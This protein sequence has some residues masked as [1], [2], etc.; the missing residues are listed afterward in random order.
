MIAVAVLGLVL[1]GGGLCLPIS[2][3]CRARTGD[4]LSR[5]AVVRPP[6]CP[7]ICRRP[8]SAP[9]VTRAQVQADF[10]AGNVSQIINY[11][12]KTYVY[13]T[14]GDANLSNGYPQGMFNLGR[15]PRHDLLGAPSADGM[16]AAQNLAWFEA[17]TAHVL[18]GP[19]RPVHFGVPRLAGE[20]TA[21]GTVD[22]GHHPNE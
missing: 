11:D 7:T 12:I 19:Q 3:L 2:W 21:G 18:P 10:A 16:T 17:G 13:D 4:F 20:P 6:F 1:A 14:T 22:L 8:C 9:G 15:R 5:T